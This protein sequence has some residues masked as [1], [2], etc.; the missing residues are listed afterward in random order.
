[1]QRRCALLALLLLLLLLTPIL[2]AAQS[3]GEEELIKAS[4]PDIADPAE[5]QPPG[6]LQIEY[7][8]DATFRAEEFRD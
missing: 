6:V 3:G 2:T 1:M 5:F 4:R 7:G 8:I